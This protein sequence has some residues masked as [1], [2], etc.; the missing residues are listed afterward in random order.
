MGSP[1]SP[2]KFWSQAI[3]AEVYNLNALQPG[4]RLVVSKFSRLGQSLGQVGAVLDALAKAGVAFVALNGLFAGEGE[5]LRLA[6]ASTVLRLHDARTFWP[7]S[8]SWPC[9]PTYR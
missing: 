8:R 1:A 2:S 7:C 3:I 9:G 6:R 5:I 4:D